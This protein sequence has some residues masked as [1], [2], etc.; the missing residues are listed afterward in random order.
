VHAAQHGER[1]GEHYGVRRQ[2]DW[3]RSVG[4]LETGAIGGEGVNVGSADLFVAVTSNVIGSQRINCDH[5]NV[6]RRHWRGPR[7]G[8]PRQQTDGR[9]K[10]TRPEE[11]HQM[12]K[13]YPSEATEKRDAGSCG[14]LIMLV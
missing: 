13:L 12:A 6:G 3:N 10:Y 8:S 1:S 11:N 9:Q 4:A 5:Y 7:G 14:V 2:C